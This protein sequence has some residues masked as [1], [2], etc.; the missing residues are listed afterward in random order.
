MSTHQQKAL[1]PIEKIRAGLTRMEPQI[2]QLLPPHID[3]GRFNLVVMSAVHR[4]P[5][6]LQ[7]DGKSLFGACQQCAQDG[8]MPDGK[9]ATLTVYK[10]KVIVDGTETWIKK[11]QYLPMILGIRKRVRESGVMADWV[12]RIVY[13]ND[14][15]EIVLGDD[16]RIE[17][18]PAISNRGKPI[19]VYSIATFKD[20]TKSREWMPIEEVNR[21]KARSKS[22]EKGPWATDY[23]EM[24]KKTV[25]RRHAKSLPLTPEI[26]RVVSRIDDLYDFDHR[27]AALAGDASPAKRIATVKTLDDIATTLEDAKGIPSNTPTAP[28]D[29]AHSAPEPEPPADHVPPRTAGGSP[30]PKAR[31]DARARGQADHAKQLSRKAVPGDLKPDRILADEWRAGWDEAEAEAR[32]MNQDGGNCE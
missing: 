7:A 29:S 14:K 3:I 32:A 30:A 5:D 26:D 17:H 27:T 8:L 13:S 19:C 31:A 1:T 9:E 22:P 6:L 23:D 16:E 10:A 21:I 28:A 25:G 11:V 20:G 2:K 24:A 4:N 15:F 18:R 12:T